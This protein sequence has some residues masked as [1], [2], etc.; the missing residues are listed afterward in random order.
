MEWDIGISC[1]C[2]YS[3]KW[4]AIEG[5]PTLTSVISTAV[6]CYTLSMPLEGA[7]VHC[8]AWSPKNSTLMD[9]LDD[10]W[11]RNHGSISIYFTKMIDQT[12]KNPHK[13]KLKTDGN[14]GASWWVPGQWEI[15]FPKHKV[16]ADWGMTAEVVLWP[17]H[18]W[19][20]VCMHTGTLSHSHALA[21]PWTHTYRHKF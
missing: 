19:T 16:A 13:K 6:L 12:G 4:M 1:C 5:M 9:V 11:E 15:L 14:S 8:H 21:H 3:L 18:T 20:H 7:Q 17:S 10:I 2:G